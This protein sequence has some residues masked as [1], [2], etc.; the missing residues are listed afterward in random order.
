M[1]PENIRTTVLRVLYNAAP[2]T[3]PISLSGLQ[4]GTL[5]FWQKRIADLEKLLEG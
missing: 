1:A 2:R 5:P 3:S 4:W